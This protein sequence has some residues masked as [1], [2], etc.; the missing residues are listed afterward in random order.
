MGREGLAHGLGE[1]TI[2]SPLRMPIKSPGKLSPTNSTPP[3]V[4]HDAFLAM[5]PGCL[6][7]PD[8]RKV[9][10]EGWS[11]LDLENKRKVYKALH[12]TIPALAC[13]PLRG[14]AG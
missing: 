8:G 10:G 5:P 11:A 13:G 7:L 2:I 12:R 3:S 9:D 14:R 4:G 1:C 6:A